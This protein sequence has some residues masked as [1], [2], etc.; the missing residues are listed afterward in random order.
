MDGDI[1]N[2]A[3]GKV[4]AR[5]VKKAI[6]EI[7]TLTLGGQDMAPINPLGKLFF[8]IGEKIRSAYPQ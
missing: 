5:Q 7:G 3:L 8:V 6:G 4:D 2:G 1:H